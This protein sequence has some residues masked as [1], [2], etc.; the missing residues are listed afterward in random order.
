MSS[1]LKIQKPVLFAF[2]TYHSAQSYTDISSS[3]LNINDPS[4]PEIADKKL[5]VI[6]SSGL[7]D[8]YDIAETVTSLLRSRL[9]LR[10]CY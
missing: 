2:V 5:E 1:I 4:S 7:L 9:E 6:P 8:S 3:Q 10:T